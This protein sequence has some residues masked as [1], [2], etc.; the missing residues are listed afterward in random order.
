[1]ANLSPDEEEQLRDTI[2]M[3]EMITQTQPDDYQ[4]LIILKEAYLKIDEE[5]DTLRISKMLA[6]AYKS[7][8]QM[9]AALMEYEAL[10]EKMPD[11]QSISEALEEMRRLTN[12]ELNRGDDRGIGQLLRFRSGKS[13]NNGKVGFEQIFVKSKMMD[14][15][16]F[17]TYWH[18]ADP[19]P[20]KESFIEYLER[21]EIMSIDDSLYYISQKSNTPFLPL[22]SYRVNLQ[23]LGLVNKS[24]CEKWKVFPFDKVSKNLL[25]ATTNPYN[26]AAASEIGKEASLKIIWYLTNPSELR[27]IIEKHLT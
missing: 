26:V 5:A 19:Y 12:D 7:T 10:F 24:Q 27:E 22:A 11:D 25:V 2:E 20:P 14:L 1:M 4:S 21:N 18:N 6:E 8:D 17:A 23:V 15:R 16:E 3:F 13:L 9:S